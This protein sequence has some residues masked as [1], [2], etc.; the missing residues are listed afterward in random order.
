MKRLMFSLVVLL[1]AALMV[2]AQ[3]PT[4]T[5]YAPVVVTIE[6]GL[7]LDP[8]SYAFATLRQ[9]TTYHVFPNI[10]DGAWQYVDMNNQPDA[11][12]D[13]DDYTDFVCTAVPGANVL[14]NF[15][16]LPTKLLSYDGPGAV[17]VEYPKAWA[18]VGGLDADAQPKTIP[19]FEFQLP[20]GVDAF[21]F[22]PEMII[23]VPMDVMPGV[24]YQGLMVVTASFTGF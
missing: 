24:D 21:S 10:A 15:Q 2:N 16:Y 19:T 12:M 20:A 13:P 7:T 6:G 11:L 5:A 17:F 23:T 22:S 3:T 4:A 18:Y 8:G 14:I 1:F 9:G